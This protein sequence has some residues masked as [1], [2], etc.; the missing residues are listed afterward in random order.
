MHTVDM[1]NYRHLTVTET[2]KWQITGVSETWT[3]KNI[4]ANL[5]SF[6]QVVVDIPKSTQTRNTTSYFERFIYRDGKFNDEEV[7]KPSQST[8][9][10]I[11]EKYESAYAEAMDVLSHFASGWKSQVADLAHYPQ[12]NHTNLRIF[13]WTHS[14][15]ISVTNAYEPL[16]VATK[17]N[18]L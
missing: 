10:Q 7:A 12:H 15:P 9:K 14:I 3:V 16:F 5:A 11:H 2:I 17:I 18:Y 8:F 6:E 4:V 13:A 1:M